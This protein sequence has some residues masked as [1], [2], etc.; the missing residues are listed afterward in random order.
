MFVRTKIICTLG[1]ATSDKKNILQLIDAG[2]N[3]ARINFSHG[4]HE[5]HARVIEIV[6]E[7]RR[8][9]HIPLAIM[10]DTKGPEIR[11]GSLKKNIDVSAKDRLFLVKDT[12]TKENSIPLVPGSVVDELKEGIDILFDDG[13]IKAKVIGHTS[14]GVEIEIIN[15]GVIKSHKGVN[16]PGTQ[17]TMPLVTD[18]D[19]EDIAFGCKL[20]VDIIAASFICTSTQVHEIRDLLLKNGSPDIRIIAKIESALG[21]KNFDSIVHAADGVMVARGDL[22]VEVPLKILP[23]LQKKFIRKSLRQEK[24]VV[25]ATQMLESMIT[26]YNPTRAEVSDVAN[27]I[28]DGASCVMLSGETAIGK[29]PVR[30]VKLM[31]SIA[32]EAE[33]DFDYPDFFNKNSREDFFDS[34]SSVAVAAVKTSYGSQARALIACTSSGATA[35]CI[36]RFRP[37]VPIL[38][39]TPFKKVYNQLSMHWGV[40]PICEK[41]SNIRES[42]DAASCAAMRD[43]LL[44]YGDLVVITA[45]SQFGVSGSTNMMIVEN[46]GEVLVRGSK[47]EGKR[48]CA[49]IAFHLN[50]EEEEDL[51]GKIVVMSRVLDKDIKNLI[52]SK[53]LI[54]QNDPSDDESVKVAARIRSELKIPV[55]LRADGAL[56]LL[57]KGD[58]VTFDP[59]KGLIF[60][61]DIRS[62]EEMISRICHHLPS[63]R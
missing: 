23:R 14:N 53:G 59:S 12:Q 36:S 18:K 44:E 9:R 26:N 27:A 8:E 60:K 35:R 20:D 48:V 39:V 13:L 58:K 15:S 49:P 30:T 54:I 19:K 47:S 11:I 63:D 45:G 16:V 28:Y 50:T 4:T 55:L 61:G 25:I 7:A 33:D 46:I 51:K 56:N 62:E 40:V 42:I 6:K 31:R 10:L 22:G 43:H 32:K 38:A 57:S 52:G 29:Y 5:E 34:S 1:P 37:S 17:F 21:V 3:V 41:T 24:P 2:M